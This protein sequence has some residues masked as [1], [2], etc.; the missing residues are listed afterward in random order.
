M[1]AALGQCY[2]WP[3]AELESLTWPDAVFWNK[4][5]ADLAKARET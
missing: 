2:G 5:A 1:L 4:A 3:R